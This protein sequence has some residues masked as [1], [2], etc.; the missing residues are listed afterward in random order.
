MRRAFRLVVLLGLVA[1]CEPTTWIERDTFPE[2]LRRD[3]GSRAECQALVDEATF[4]LNDCRKYLVGNRLK[5]RSRHVAKCSYE[6]RDVQLAMANTERYAARERVETATEGHATPAG[7]LIV[8]KSVDGGAEEAVDGGAAATVRTLAPCTDTPRPPPFGSIVHMRK[9]DVYRADVR[10]TEGEWRPRGP[11]GTAYHHA[12]RVEFVN[13]AA[14]APPSDS[15]FAH[16]SF[17]IQSY[18]IAPPL[19]GQNVLRVTYYAEVVDAC[20]APD[21]TPPPTAPLQP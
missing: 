4:R 20:S 12:T 17:R 21:P 19:K 18:R 10:F 16:F 5:Y 11:I 7:V 9:N 14:F 15:A 3:C 2:R 6:F 1:G 13:G 8:E